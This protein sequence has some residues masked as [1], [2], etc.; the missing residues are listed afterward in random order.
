[1]DRREFLAGAATGTLGTLAG[2]TNLLERQSTR[3]PPLVEDRPDAVYVPT[4][5]EGMEMVGVKSSGRY[6]LALFYSFPHRF[7]LMDDDRTNKVEIGSEDSLHLMASVWD[8]ETETAIPSSNASLTVEQDGGTV[9][10]KRMWPMLSQNMGFHYGDNVALD[11]DGVY[12]AT[13]AF[14][15]VSVR[16]TGEFADA[17][18]EQVS[19]SFRFEFRRDA[20]EGQVSFEE[21]PDRQ[22]ERD[23]VEPMSMDMAPTPQLPPAEEMPGTTLGTGTSGDARFVATLLDERPEG[24]DGDGPYLAVS[25]RT[26]YNRFPIPMMALSATLERDGET[27]FDGNLTS[28]LDPDL[29]YHYGAAVDGVEDGDRLTITVDSPPGVSRHEGYE[30]TFLDM[31]PVEMDVTL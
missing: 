19:P 25:P 26:P 6:S 11:G 21:L 5:V 20:L 17:F 22:G 23:A 28:T 4:H 13:V 12:D 1:M 24:V 31:E 2:C 27:A 29:K 8:A 30:T 16:R 10:R 15:P 3:A 18:E 14:G 7:W 9:V